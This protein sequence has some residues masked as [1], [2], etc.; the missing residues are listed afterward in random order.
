[1]PKLGEVFGIGA[2]V[3]RH[4]YVDRAGLD[5]KFTYL[6]EQDRHL[7]IYGPSKQGKTIL[8]KKNLAE[9]KCIVIQ[10]RANSSLEQ[11]YSEILR[12]IGTRIPTEISETLTYGLEIKSKA[13]AQIN[14]PFISS[15]SGE[16]EGSG[17]VEKSLESVAEI[18][19]VDEKSLGFVT[20]EIKNSEKKVVIEDFHYLPENERKR[21]AFDLKAFWDNSTFFIIIGIWA[22]QN[23]LTY[24]NGDLSGRVAEIDVQWTN[25]ELAELLLKGEK[26]LNINFAHKI[27]QEIISDANQNVGLLQRI[28]EK[29]CFESGVVETD[30]KVNLD[31]QTALERCRSS[32]CSEESARYRQFCDSVSRG[33][34]GYEE[35]ELKVYQR[36]LR[37]CIEASDSEI[38]NGLNSSAILNRINER[39][40]H[41]RKSDLT[42]A[43]NRIDRLQAERS[44]SPLVIS[45]NHNS[46]KVQ[47]VDRELLFYRKYGSPIWPWQEA[48]DED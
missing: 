36:I 16:L 45:Y 2:S 33:F 30:W 35:S 40:P 42:A 26:T 15:G 12:R 9:D 24:Y 11:I 28:A 17:D 46:R 27:K 5:R 8:R 37:A 44:I 23:L 7:V 22:E 41:V 34:K 38:C 25:Q 21:L 14:L 47:L 6:V 32:I 10:C 20:E 1:M 39:E 4:T 3:P 29:F 31:N 18:A 43:L 48:N 19:G 13:S